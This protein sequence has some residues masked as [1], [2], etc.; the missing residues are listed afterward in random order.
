[1]RDPYG[2]SRKDVRRR[3]WRAAPGPNLT[4]Q[5]LSYT[6]AAV[7]LPS[8]EDIQHLLDKARRRNQLESV[9]G[10]LLYCSGS[11]HQYLEGPLDG[12]DRVYAAI[13]RDPL[14]HHIF[15]MLRE[16][17]EAREF[18]GWSMGF[19]GEGHVDGPD[20]AA[21][22]ELLVDESAKLSGGRLL[23]NAFWNTG[24]GARYRAALLNRRPQP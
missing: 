8:P 3:G 2:D 17:I 6:S 22:T 11:F 15:E 23:L 14:H 12:L 4:L 9:T 20:E 13:C 1:M 5:S 10:V 24:L 19:R 21:L 18:E 16:P 7:R